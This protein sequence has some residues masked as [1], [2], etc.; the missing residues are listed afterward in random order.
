MFATVTAALLAALAVYAYLST[1]VTHADSSYVPTSAVKM[2]NSLT[3]FSADA[4]LNG[5]ASCTEDLISG[6]HPD[7]T[8][9]LEMTTG[10]NFTNVVTLSPSGATVSTVPVGTKVGG[11]KSATTLGIG[12]TTCYQPIPVEFVLYNVALPKT[13]GGAAT[14]VRASMVNIAYPQQEG[15]TDRFGRWKI[16]GNA[17][18]ADPVVTNTDG[19][20][21]TPA[22]IPL[23]NYPSYL[24]DLFDDDFVPGIGDGAD[25]PLIPQ[26]VYG[27]LTQ[28][29][30]TW[31][32]LFFAQFTPGV[33]TVLPQPLGSI[34]SQMGAPSVSVLND[35]TSVAAFPSSITDFCTPLLVKTMLLG[36]PSGSRWTNP[37]QGTSF[38]VQYNESQRDLDQ[39]GFENSLDPCPILK[40]ASNPKADPGPEPL[41]TDG[42][43]IPNE[44]GCD[45]TATSALDPFFGDEDHD[46]FQNRGDNCPFTAN[47]DPFSA[48]PFV[49]PGPNEQVESELSVVPADKGPRVD[50]IGDVCDSEF[51]AITVKGQN[52][53]VDNAGVNISI[54]MSDSV[55]NGRYMTRTNVN[56]VCFRTSAISIPGGSDNDA[57]GYCNLSSQDL[58]NDG[59]AGDSCLTD[60]PVSCVAKHTAWAPASHPGMS[61][62]TDGDG[63]TDAMETYQGTDPVKTCNKSPTANDEI[64]DN[65]TQDFNDDRLVTGSDVLKFSTGYGKAVNGT[66][67]PFNRVDF[68]NDGLITGSDVLKLSTGFG[69]QCGVDAGVPVAFSQ[70]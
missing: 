23:A 60:S 61:M 63:T 21:A 41:D 30:G 66:G 52:T 16:G 7:F 14:N 59:A 4:T 37:A 2:C 67:G 65:W 47:G 17:T 29:A 12:N 56:A 8:Q 31:V 49:T 44:A 34:T 69:K 15:A 68:N 20:H 28:V 53:T 45:T 19:S 64:L 40:D 51:G 54:T 5:S 9:T 35:P 36:A 58:G 62:D 46:G 42:D 48:N 57:D 3:S 25:N 43:G 18:I 6:S 1:G 70:Q 39:D 26:A 22:A 10:L 38:F 24:L 55:A 50:S 32:P 27:G 33:L 13:S 11:L